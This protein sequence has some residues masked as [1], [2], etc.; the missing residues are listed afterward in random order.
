[1]ENKIDA[2]SKPSKL[3][4]K[5]RGGTK[6]YFRTFQIVRRQKVFNKGF[7]K[8]K[9]SKALKRNPKPRLMQRKKQHV[10]QE[11]GPK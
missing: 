11:Y 6:D 7:N 10:Q 3:K 4:M 1:M 2:P 9:G 8:Q 5:S